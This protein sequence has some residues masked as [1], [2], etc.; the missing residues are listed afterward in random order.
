MLRRAPTTITLTQADIEQYEA[1]RQRK[2]QEKKQ[3]QQQQQQEEEQGASIQSTNASDQTVVDQP[4][5][6][7]KK[8]RIMGSGRGN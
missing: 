1:N 5:V 2:L 7:S 4:P 6:K 8:D 3:Q